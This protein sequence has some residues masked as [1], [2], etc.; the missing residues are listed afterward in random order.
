MSSEGEIT[1]TKPWEAGKLTVHPN[2]TYLVNGDQPFFWLGDTA[3]TLFQRLSIHHA[4]TYLINRK[5]KGFN[6]IQS[7]LINVAHKEDP[8]SHQQI[9]NED[10]LKT[11]APDN[12][13]YW[14]RVVE[15]VD[16]AASE[17]I[18]F[19]L[20]PVWGKVAKK[21]Y[22]HERNVEAYAD[23]LA[24]TFKDKPN[25]LWLLGGDTRGDL[26]PELWDVFGQKLKTSMP[27]ILVGYHP[28]G[29]TSSSYWFHEK[30]WLDFNMFQSGHRRYDQ[31]ALQSW[32]DAYAQEPWYG[33]DNW[34]Y[35][36]HDLAKAP[37]KPVMDGEPSYEQIPQGLHDSSEPYW[38]A[39]HTRRYAYWSVL[40]GAFGHTYGHNAIF[41][42]N[43]V[44]YKSEYGVNATWAEALH[45]SG[46]NQMQY[47]KELMLEI[48]FQE[49]ERMQSILY[50][51]EALEP[52]EDKILAFGSDQHLVVYTY[53]GKNFSLY[54]PDANANYK[55]YW[56]D[57]VNGSRSY[58]GL[59]SLNEAVSFQPPSKDTDFTDWVLLLVATE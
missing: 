21:G 49:C 9:E 28:F 47:L 31:P 26:E 45:A 52:K 46:G 4:K 58:T 15:L 51:E 36:L 5:E 32:D 17:G 16:F 53:S 13:S 38:Q 24:E 18:Y 1:L 55:A 7:I 3:W 14:K 27:D 56:I 2:Q 41:Q 10:V 6:V 48:Q 25:I 59:Y 30:E 35:V 23:F 37:T 57:P 40:S 33:E 20:L 54:N 11:I 43:G 19:A 42:F 39:H 44:G 8:V 22:L 34:Q 12:D 50:P 29:R